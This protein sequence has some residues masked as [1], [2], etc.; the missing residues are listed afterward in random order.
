MEDYDARLEAE[1]ERA[2]AMEGVPDEEGWITV[3]KHGKRPVIPRSDAVNQKIASAEKK[4][5]AQKEL[6]NFYTFQIR[7]SKM[8]RI[9]EL[10]K[11][12]EEDKR[13]ISLM[14]ASRRFRPV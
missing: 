9:A 6:V 13:R 3:T 7:E 11:K 4:K 2:K 10:R 12:F 1:K 8:E 5:R 14:K